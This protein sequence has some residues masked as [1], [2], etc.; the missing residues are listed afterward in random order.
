MSSQDLY[1]S[2]EKSVFDIGNVFILNVRFLECKAVI[3]KDF[4]DF[5]KMPI[6]RFFS[7]KYRYKLLTLIMIC[8]ILYCNYI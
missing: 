7:M 6:Y 3:L 4:I 2:N 8:D 1:A 5:S